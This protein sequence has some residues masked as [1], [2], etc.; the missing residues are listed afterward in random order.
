[1]EELQMVSD[2]ELGFADVELT[3]LKK[4]VYGYWLARVCQLEAGDGKVVCMKV[5]LDDFLTNDMILQL[6]VPVFCAPGRG[7]TKRNLGR[8]AYTHQTELFA[9]LGDELKE[10]FDTRQRELARTV[11]GRPLRLGARQADPR[12]WELTVF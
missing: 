11:G 6:L 9:T 12:M 2:K 7:H 8:W 4:L 1:M 3:Q 10:T 5:L